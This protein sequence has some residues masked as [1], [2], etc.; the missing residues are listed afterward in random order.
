MNIDNHSSPEEMERLLFENSDEPAAEFYGHLQDC[1]ECQKALDETA[2]APELWQKVS[3]FIDPSDFNSDAR[4]SHTARF[5]SHGNAMDGNDI[6]VKNRRRSS[7]FTR[8]SF[9]RGSVGGQIRC[10]N[11]YRNWTIQIGVERF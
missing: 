2:A 7:G 8:K 5:D 3:D 6:G 10:Q 9:S 11:F 1:P 4:L